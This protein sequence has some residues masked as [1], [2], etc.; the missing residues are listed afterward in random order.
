M[1]EL[2]KKNIH[3]FSLFVEQIQ[4]K[5]S[6]QFARIGFTKLET[7][8]QPWISWLEK[9][10]CMQTHRAV[11]QPVRVILLPSA[12]REKNEKVN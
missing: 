12:L 2:Y 11:Y 3:P 7:S 10:V 6:F 5:R 4:E 9:N 1:A 8:W